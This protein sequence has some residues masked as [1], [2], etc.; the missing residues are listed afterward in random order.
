MNKRN[1]VML[2]GC[3]IEGILKALY[4][5]FGKVLENFMWFSWVSQ[6][7]N[8]FFNGVFSRYFVI[9]LMGVTDISMEFKG[10]FYE[11]S[12]VSFYLNFMGV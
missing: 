4:K 7:L 12:R 1:H 11:V 5:D 3:F 10:S 8:M 6:G 2:H 9:Y